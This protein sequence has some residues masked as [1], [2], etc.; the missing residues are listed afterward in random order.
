V[1]TG[2]IEPLPEASCQENGRLL[3]RVREAR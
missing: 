3:P 2:N 1:H